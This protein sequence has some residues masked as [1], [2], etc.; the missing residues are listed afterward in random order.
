MSAST[1]AQFASVAVGEMKRRFQFGAARVMVNVALSVTDE[2][3]GRT[4]VR[5]GRARS[6]W[7]VSVGEPN[8]ADLDPYVQYDNEKD[9][10]KLNETANRAA[11]VAAAKRSLA[12]YKD[13]DIFLANDVTDPKSGDKYIQA[14][15]A[16][17]SDQAPSNFTKL[18]I[19]AGIEK[20]PDID[21]FAAEEAS[22]LD[23]GLP[24]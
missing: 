12:G 23:G 10:N 14:L 9:Y 24:F 8:I 3:A 20:A 21:V 4:P 11:V 2:I 1:L 13:G 18:S 5:T 15:D 7:Q 22:F 17:G 6:N 16:N 19:I